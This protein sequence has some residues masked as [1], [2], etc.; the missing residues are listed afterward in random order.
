MI[1]DNQV[2]RKQAALDELGLHHSL[3]DGNRDALEKQ[4]RI[5]AHLQDSLGFGLEEDQHHEVL[6]LDLPA[7]EH[8]FSD[9]V[10]Q[11]H[12]RYDLIL[13]WKFLSEFYNHARGN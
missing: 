10:E 9:F 11:M 13:C 2:T 5:L 1:L 6:P 8:A 12:G 7:F 3:L 4:H